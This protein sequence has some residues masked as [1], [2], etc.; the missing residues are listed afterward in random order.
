MTGL[1]VASTL[2]LAIL[3]AGFAFR[4]SRRRHRALMLLAFAIDIGLVVW[5]EA[6]RGAVEQVAPGMSA[7]LAFHIV[8]STA[9]LFAY[10]GMIGLGKRLFGGRLD[11]Q[12][13]HRNL[14][15]GFVVLRSLN[16]VTSFLV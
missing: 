9:V 1:H 4:R 14:G 5:I 11:L 16:Y 13:W 3:V 12:T 8:V 10:V 7:L 6:T 15:I 2:V